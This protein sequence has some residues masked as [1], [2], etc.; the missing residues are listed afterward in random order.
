MIQPLQRQG[1]KYIMDVVLASNLFQARE[2]KFLN[3]CR[4]YLQVLT[5]SDMYN[6]Q[7]DALAVGIY[8]G[9]RS[10]TQSRSTLLEPFQ[11]RPNSQ[12]WP[13]WR[14]FLRHITTDGCWVYDPL[15]QWQAGLS[16]R[17][18]W[19]SYYSATLR[20]MDVGCMTL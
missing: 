1:D 16:T 13:L 4:L 17:R 20:L 15:G 5:L 14:R 18:Q 7:G 6:A 11:E 3:Y 19:P 10:H 9:Y 12:V 8:D 2:V